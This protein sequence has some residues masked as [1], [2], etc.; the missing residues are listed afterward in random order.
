MRAALVVSA[1][2]SLG[3]GVLGYTSGIQYN[4]LK[5][6]QAGTSNFF[7]NFNF[8]TGADP[9][10]GF[11]QSSTSKKSLM[12]DTNLNPVRRSGLRAAFPTSQ[13]ITGVKPLVVDPPLASN[14]KLHSPKSSSSLNSIMSLEGLPFVILSDSSQCGVW[15]A[16]WTANLTNWPN[17]GEIDIIEGVNNQKK[18]SFAFHTSN[19]CVV[20][21]QSQSGSL[22]TSNCYVSAPGQSYNAG[23]GGSAAG[24]NT[25]GD[26]MNA[27]GG[28]I[29]AMD[30][31][32]EGIRIWFFPK[33][34]YPA[35]IAAGKPAISGWGTVLHFEMLL[36]VAYGGFAEQGV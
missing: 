3:H 18:N 28:G 27:I 16:F 17:G 11:V 23:C 36:T 9:T 24:T 30:W 34:S 19:G 29:Y 33:G 21:G 32:K 14:P 5:D 13:Q 15:P 6:F 7:N 1:G 22:A 20:S 10:H 4:L 2:L 12:V 8:Y 35:D 25:Y 31:R 26:G